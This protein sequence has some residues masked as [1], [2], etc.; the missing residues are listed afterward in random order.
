MPTRSSSA[1]ESSIPSSSRRLLRISSRP[2]PKALLGAGVEAAPGGSGRYSVTLRWS[3]S[4]A[5]S[6]PELRPRCYQICR[7]AD[8]LRSATP[9]AIINRAIPATTARSMPVNGSVPLAP[10]VDAFG[11]V[12]VAATAGPLLEPLVCVPWTWCPWSPGPGTAARTAPPRDRRAR[13]ERRQSPAAPP[14]PHRP[15]P[16]AKPVDMNASFETSAPILI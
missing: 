6:L 14:L 2:V 9:A 13:L 4:S 8:N 10:S 15:P 12:A 7:G 5:R 16:Q 11:A 3:A 1:S